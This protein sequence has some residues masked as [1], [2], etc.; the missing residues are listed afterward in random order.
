MKR[1]DLNVI[2]P[3]KGLIQII[4]PNQYLITSTFIRFAEFYEGQNDKLRGHHFT[5]DDVMD[6]YV[7]KFGLMSYFEDWNGFNI[8]GEAFDEAYKIFHQ[9]LRDKERIV[10]DAV[11]DY[12]LFQDGTRQPFDKYYVIATHPEYD[13]TNHE[14]AHALFYLDPGYRAMVQFFISQIDPK[15]KQ[16]LVKWLLNEGYCFQVIDDEINSY[17]MDALAGYERWAEFL[18]DQQIRLAAENL[19]LLFNEK[20]TRAKAG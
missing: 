11:M 5:L 18:K 8:P 7:E 12:K 13:C 2:L 16:P 14:M 20:L 10:V 15:S 6:D 4:F 3:F 17:I 1:T 9:D 19:N